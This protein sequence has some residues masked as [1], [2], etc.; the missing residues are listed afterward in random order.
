MHHRVEIVFQSNLPKLSD[1]TLHGEDRVI[2]ISH[3]W[4]FLEGYYLVMKATILVS[5]D[6][7]II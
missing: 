2:N 3:Y 4:R 1:G 6:V 7:I 5:K